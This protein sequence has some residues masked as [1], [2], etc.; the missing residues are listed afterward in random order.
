MTFFRRHVLFAPSSFDSYAG[1]TFPGLVDLMWRIDQLSAK[2][3]TQKWEDVKRHLATIIYTVESA[4]SV[5]K[6]TTQFN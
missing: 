3:Q 1:A 4:I 5:L 6:P 2:E